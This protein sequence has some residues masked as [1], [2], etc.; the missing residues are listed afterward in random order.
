MIKRQ[1]SCN[2]IKNRLQH[3]CFHV[4]FAK[5]LWTPFLQKSFSGCFWGLSYVFKGVWSKKQRD[6]Q[7]EMSDSA[8][9]RYLLPRKSRSSHRWC[10]VKEGLQGSAQM[11][12]CEC[13][14]IFKNT[15]FEISVNG[16]SWKSPPQWQIY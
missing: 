5:F 8:E 4:K 12:T 10:S 9:K 2:S 15:N 16:C 7:Q 1:T 13:C 3:R 6:C 11:F 14:E